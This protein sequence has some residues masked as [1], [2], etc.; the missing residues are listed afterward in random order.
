[1]PWDPLPSE[2]PIARTIDQPLPSLVSS[3]GVDLGP[4]GGGCQFIAA[5]APAEAYATPP[6]R[7]AGKCGRPI[8]RHSP[9]CAEHHRLCVRPPLPFKYLLRL[10][11][12]RAVR[13]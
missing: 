8:V 10:A 1:M 2:L 4:A 6:G 3:P 12:L 11:G 7:G 13:R 9:Y 5:G